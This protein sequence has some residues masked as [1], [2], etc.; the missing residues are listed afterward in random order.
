[1]SPEGRLT[2]IL[3][4]AW[5]GLNA[6]PVGSMAWTF[7]AKFMTQII[8]WKATGKAPVRKHFFFGQLNISLCSVTGKEKDDSFEKFRRMKYFSHPQNHLVVVSH[9]SIQGQIFPYAT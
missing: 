2:A 8:S 7:S 3:S 9:Q 6:S 5:D 4:L 1:M